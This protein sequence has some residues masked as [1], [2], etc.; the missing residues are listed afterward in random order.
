MYKIRR[1]SSFFSTT[2]RKK[3]KPENLMIYW[4]FL[5]ERV[6]FLFRASGL[7]VGSHRR[8]LA[9]RRKSLGGETIRPSNPTA[10]LSK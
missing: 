4:L 3:E 7:E 6:G 8:L 1:K 5:A 9:L 2:V 10:L